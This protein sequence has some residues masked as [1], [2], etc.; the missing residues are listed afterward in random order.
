MVLSVPLLY[1][2]LWRQLLPRLLMTLI[3]LLTQDEAYGEVDNVA[4]TLVE[5]RKKR[6][7]K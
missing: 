1:T 3:V 2:E 7:V 6:S 5:T 4:S